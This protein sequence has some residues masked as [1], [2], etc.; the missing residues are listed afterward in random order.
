M[1]NV[2]YCNIEFDAKL[3]KNGSD[4]EVL[5]D[6]DFMSFLDSRLLPLVDGSYIKEL[7]CEN[8]CEFRLNEVNCSKKT[9]YSWNCNSS[10]LTN[11]N[12]LIK[13]S[14]INCTNVLVLKDDQNPCFFRYSLQKINNRGFDFVIL[15]FIILGLV[16]LFMFIELFKKFFA[17]SSAF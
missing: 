4:F 2:I 16:V 13:D 5:Y 10:S 3:F 9:L 17:C 12:Y 15:L 11:S 8:R 6:I 1:I 7:D 14:T